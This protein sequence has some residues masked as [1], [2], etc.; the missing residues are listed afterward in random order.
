MTVERNKEKLVYLLKRKNCERA[1][2][3]TIFLLRSRKPVR[4]TPIAGKAD[5]EFF[6][7]R[8][9]DRNFRSDSIGELS[10]R[11]TPVTSG[12]NSIFI[13]FIEIIYGAN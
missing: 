5:I 10:A 1:L 8:P 7:V 6:F 4:R 12:N 2:L 11:F 3:L 9:Y 13:L